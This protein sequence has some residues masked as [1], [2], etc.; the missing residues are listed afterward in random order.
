MHS[1]LS[2]GTGDAGIWRTHRLT[3][4]L[5]LHAI[6]L[7]SCITLHPPIQGIVQGGLNEGGE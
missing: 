4:A 1:S 5:W 3:V 6:T 7:A 2:S